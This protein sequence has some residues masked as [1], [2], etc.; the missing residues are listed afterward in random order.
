MVHTDT[1]DGTSEQTRIRRT[2]HAVNEVASEPHESRRRGAQHW[3]PRATLLET[4]GDSTHGPDTPAAMSPCRGTGAGAAGASFSLVW[5][6]SRPLT[7]RRCVN[8]RCQVAFLHARAPSYVHG[9]YSRSRPHVQRCISRRPLSRLALFMLLHVSYSTCSR[10]DASD[11][12]ELH[13]VTTP[14]LTLEGGRGRP[15]GLAM[16]AGTRAT[17][18]GGSGEESCGM[19]GGAASCGWSGAPGVNGTHGGGGISLDS[20]G[21]GRALS[22][23]PFYT[24]AEWFPLP[25]A[26]STSDYLSTVHQCVPRHQVT[27]SSAPP[28]RRPGTI[29][30]EVHV[31][32]LERSPV[33]TRLKQLSWKENVC[34]AL[35]SG[36][37]TGAS[38]AV[39]PVP[40]SVPPPPARDLAWLLANTAGK[41]RRMDWRSGLGFNAPVPPA[42]PAQMAELRDA[43][44]STFASISMEQRRAA[45]A[46]SMLHAWDGYRW[47][48]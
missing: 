12:M 7:I 1:E 5:N 46:G 35:V 9:G 33:T 23:E 16:A 14:A 39:P 18:G 2:R 3:R 28:S 45:V 24:L 19:D 21:T 44:P 25:L 13:S 38:A 6:T 20:S 37:S 40:P 27:V 11:E 31:R 22:V 10:S 17:S 30:F 34:A 41:K 8:C 32:K 15:A 47:G 42:T 26:S 48:L 36:G 4:A 29:H 43:H